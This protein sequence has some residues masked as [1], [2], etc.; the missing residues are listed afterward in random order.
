MQGHGGAAETEVGPIGANRVAKKTT[1]LHC[2]S[3][4]LWF[5]LFRAAAEEKYGKELVNIARKAGGLYEIWYAC[6]SA[7]I[8][9]SSF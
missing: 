4:L 6:I 2:S 8:F 1:T 3:P 9:I 7:Q 5:Y